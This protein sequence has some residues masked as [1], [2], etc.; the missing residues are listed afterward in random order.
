MAKF[1]VGAGLGILIGRIFGRNGFYGLTSLA[2]IS[3]VTNSNGSIFLT[4]MGNYGDEADSGCFPILSLN[5]GPFFM[6]LALGASGLGNIP[7]MSLLAAIIPVLVGMIL[8]NLDRGLKELFEPMGTAIIPL[9]GFALGT[10][11][12]LTSI[13][14]GGFPGVLLGLITVFAGGGFILIFDRLLNR[15]PGSAVWAVADYGR[16]CS[17]GTRSSGIGRS[18]SAARRRDS[19][20]AGCSFCCSHLYT[21]TA[22]HKLAGQKNSHVQSC[23]WKDRI[24]ISAFGIPKDQYKI[25]LYV[26]KFIWIKI[27]LSKATMLSGNLA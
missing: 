6:L 7:F 8:G 20:S 17:C 9:I 22:R 13:I 2:V 12:N 27:K 18:I 15:R 16:K 19:N 11:I 10:G 4:L 26:L 23:H 24:L 3:A 1:I 14:K 21:G 5:D 25:Y